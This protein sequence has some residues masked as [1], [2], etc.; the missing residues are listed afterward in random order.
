MTGWVSAQFAFNGMA[1]SNTARL[2]ANNNAQALAQLINIFSTFG[3]LPP[4]P[5]LFVYAVARATAT[6][7]PQ[8]SGINWSNSVQPISGVQGLSLDFFWGSSLQQKYGDIFGGS[9]NFTLGG[10]PYSVSA[11][12]LLGAAVNSVAIGAVYNSGAGQ[13]VISDIIFGNAGQYIGAQMQGM[14]GG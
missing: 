11:S 9:Q 2:F 14:I 6:L 12:G 3:Q 4:N 7:T 5:E 1:G 13:N 10:P 8:N